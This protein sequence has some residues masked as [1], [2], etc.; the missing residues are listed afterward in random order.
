MFLTLNIGRLSLGWAVFAHHPTWV[1]STRLPQATPSTP[2][3]AL[4][5]HPGI[6]SLS[7]AFLTLPGSDTSGRQCPYP[8]GLRHASVSP[9]PV[10]DAG[11]C[12]AGWCGGGTQ[13]CPA[14]CDPMGCSPPGSS[15]HGFPGRNTGVRCHFLLQGSSRPR[16]R[17]LH[18]LHWG[19]FFTS[20]PPGEP[21]LAWPHLMA[22]FRTVFFF[23]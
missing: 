5:P 4:E 1:L 8:A 18:L 11:V 19:R 20:L 13:L 12:L 14:L 16:D 10:P 17:N 7:D 2:A 6:P 22:S 9:L 21:H 15:V 23:F 3:W